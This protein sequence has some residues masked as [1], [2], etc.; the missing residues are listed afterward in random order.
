MKEHAFE[1]FLFDLPVR[2]C[3]IVGNGTQAAYNR[4][5]RLERETE[6]EISADFIPVVRFAVASDLHVHSASDP[7]NADRFTEL[8]RTAY[9]YADG[10]PTYQG[11]DAVLLAG[12]IADNG[13]DGEFEEIRRVIRENMRKSTVLVPVM[14]NHEFAHAGRNGFARQM[15]E[16]LEIHKTVKGF[17]VIGMAPEPKDTWHTPRQLLWMRRELKKAALDDP[18]KPIFTLQHGHI[19]KTVYVSRTWYTQASPLL[20][21]I[22]AGYPQIINFSGHSHGPVN[23]PL[24]VWQSKYTLFGTGT[25][26]YFEMERDLSDNTVPQGSENAAQYLIVEVDAENRTRV[27]PFDLISDSFFR[28]PSNTDDPGKQLIYMI[29]RPWDRA[30]FAYTSERRKTDIPPHFTKEA[31]ISF[32]EIGSDAVSICF[33]QALSDVCTYGYRIVVRY[34]GK[35]G[36]PVAVK[37]IYSGYYFQPMPESCFCHIEGLSPETAYDVEVIPLNVWRH[38][39]ESLKAVFSTT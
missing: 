15:G 10:H 16:P 33:P 28:T 13:A 34:A 5:K 7:R 35:H 8:F 39:G 18:R 1:R 21:P 31:E 11:L 37:E 30:C 32:R 26:N 20:H 2:V 12:D 3:R 19:W 24:S 22:Y 6:A 14:G 9:A 25:L 29:P 36:K 17:H 27:M 23:H 38:E 4:Q